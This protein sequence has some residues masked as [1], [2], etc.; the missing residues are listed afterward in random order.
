MNQLRG[1][2]KRDQELFHSIMDKFPEEFLIDR[3]GPW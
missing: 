3:L 2:E 1:T